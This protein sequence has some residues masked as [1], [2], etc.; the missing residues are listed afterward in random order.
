MGFVPG[1]PLRNL[2]YGI[3]H[4]LQMARDK[5]ILFIGLVAPAVYFLGVWQGWWG[6]FLIDLLQKTQG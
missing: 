1:K 5:P 3:T 4:P 2:I 6:N